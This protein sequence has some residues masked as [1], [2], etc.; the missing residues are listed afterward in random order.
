MMSRGPGRPF[1]DDVRQGGWCGHEAE[2][3]FHV[4]TS[5][6]LLSARF[7]WHSD[8]PLAVLVPMDTSRGL[9]TW[10]FAMSL[11]LDALI[12][13]GELVGIGD[14]RIRVTCGELWLWLSSPH[15]RAVLTCDALVATEFSEVVSHLMASW[16][17]PETVNEQLDLLLEKI[18]G[19]VEL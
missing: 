11:L 7:C 17:L 8:D 5:G 4:E 15:G 10:G 19:E 6:E 13:P 9:V 12:Q 16:D 2:V 1:D 18:E 3:T 14:V